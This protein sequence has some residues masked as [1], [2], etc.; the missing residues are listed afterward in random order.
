MTRN[1]CFHTHVSQSY[2]HAGCGAEHG[3]SEKRSSWE[4]AIDRRREV[5][6]KA[7]EFVPFS[8]EAG[9]AWGPAARRFFNE[10]LELADGERNVDLYHWS[11]AKFSSTWYDTLSVLVVAKDGLK[12]E[13]PHRVVTG[14]SAF[15]ICS[16]QIMKITRWARRALVMILDRYRLCL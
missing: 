13:L 12:S 1:M 6:T 14:R 15:G 3:E 8:I 11:S 2:T 4:D 16:T 9:G 7:V 10:C 5:S